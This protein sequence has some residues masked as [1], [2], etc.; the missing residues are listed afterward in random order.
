MIILTDLIKRHKEYKK[1]TIDNKINVGDY[2]KKVQED[3]NSELSDDGWKNLG[4]QN[5]FP[6][7]TDNIDQNGVVIN[8][9]FIKND[10]NNNSLRN[11][12]H[13]YELLKKNTLLSKYK[14]ILEIG[15]GCGILASLL[16]QE[17]KKYFI[18]DIPNMILCSSSYLMTIFPNKKY[19][20][21]NELTKSVDLDDKDII[22]ITPNQI[23]FLKDNYFDLIINNQSFQEM[24]YS[25]IDA[26]FNLIKRSLKFEGKFFSSN[27]LKKETNYFDYPWKILNNFKIKR[28]DLLANFK[29][30]EEDKAALRSAYNTQEQ[31]A[32]DPV[33]SE[34]IVEINN[35]QYW[36][37]SA[38]TNP[39][40]AQYHS[41]IALRQHQ[42]RSQNYVDYAHRLLQDTP[43]RFMLCEDS[44]YLRE[45]DVSPNSWC[46]H[47]E[48]LGMTSFK[49]ISRYYKEDAKADV[50]QPI[51][52]VQFDFIRK[53][54]QPCVDFP[55][56]NEREILAVENMLYKKYHDAIINKCSN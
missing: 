31:I 37:S 52:L 27:R 53:Y 34:N 25:E 11:N 16:L 18:V 17:K 7:K 10:S 44:L 21:P 33:Y 47:D 38:S 22:F 36:L 5:F 45:T 48:Y 9:T 23:K 4:K 20:L 39:A 56:R 40:V 50:I 2:W 35:D 46:W 13:F 14:N 41:T 28:E 15:A 32:L 6:I 29:G 54:V 3:F 30:T 1:F 43:Y 49:K 19:C 8:R 55:W 12:N 26:Y 42:I 24:N 51:S